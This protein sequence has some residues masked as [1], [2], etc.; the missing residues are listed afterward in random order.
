MAKS[1]TGLIPRY[2]G[3]F[4]P[5]LKVICAEEVR[6]LR[7]KRFLIWDCRGSA[8]MPGNSDIQG[9][10]S[11]FG[12]F[13]TTIL[14]LWPVPAVGLQLPEIKDA[15]GDTLFLVPA[16]FTR[17]QPGYGAGGYCRRC[18]ASCIRS[19]ISRKSPRYV[20]YAMF[21]ILGDTVEGARA[22][23]RLMP[24]DAVRTIL[25]DTFKDEAEE[26]LRQALGP[27]LAGDVRYPGECGAV[28]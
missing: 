3:D 12:V 26:A 18:R 24:D 22:Y 20:P 28:T 1:L 4:S 25:I 14:G 10:Y 27:D 19:Q 11:E 15:A 16:M 7:T 8:G 13:E 2:R 9:P 17:P 5:P 6:N 21:I 23:N